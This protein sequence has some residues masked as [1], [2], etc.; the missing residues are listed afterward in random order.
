[1]VTGNKYWCTFADGAD[2]ISVLCRIDEPGVTQGPRGP[3]VSVSIEK[4]KGELPAGVTGS[5]L[6]MTTLSPMAR[7]P[8]VA[9]LRP[10]SNTTG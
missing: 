1:M 4:P 7:F 10:S 3:T 8:G 5:P 9:P 2:F 6:S